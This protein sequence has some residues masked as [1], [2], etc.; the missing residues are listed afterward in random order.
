MPQTPIAAYRSLISSGALD[1][2]PAQAAAMEKLQLLANRLARYTPPARTDW[3]T[4][5]TRKRGEV[6]RGLYL[7][8]GVGRGKTLLMDLFFEHVPFERKR[9]THFHAFMADIHDRIAAARRSSHGDPIASIA[10]ELSRESRLICFDELHVTD[11]ADAM[12][13][14]RLFDALFQ[15]YVVV[16]STSNSAPGELYK[17]G[18]NRQLFLPFIRLIEDNME[19]MALEAAKDYRLEKLSGRP[20]YFTPLGDKATE[21]LREAWISLA[22]VER[23]KHCR[24]PFKGREIAVPEAHLGVAFFQ[25]ADLCEQPLAAAD[26]LHIA[27]TFHTVLIDAIPILG[28]RLH[29]EARRFI[30]LIDTLY[31]NRIRLIAAADGEP[32]ALYVEGRGADLFAR[33]AS[34][35]VEMR[36]QAYVAGLVG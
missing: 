12:V 28:P 18:L 29:N 23:G 7:F 6:P 31:D 3:F 8:G 36:S 20:L 21:A 34:R 30:N 4:Y 22:G 13:L 25:F 32:H 19:V 2:D 9:R 1:H 24:L 17:D 14:G 27:H 33:T 26:Y 15:H 16:V 11:I 35:L 5:F 10:N